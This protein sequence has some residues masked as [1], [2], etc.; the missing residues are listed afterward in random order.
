MPLLSGYE[1]AS[2]AYDD[3]IYSREVKR[4]RLPAAIN[5]IFRYSNANIISSCT[6]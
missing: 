2:Q 6:K 5:V 1:K 4:I 3:S